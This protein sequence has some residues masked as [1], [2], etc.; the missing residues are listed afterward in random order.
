MGPDTVDLGP[1]TSQLTVYPILRAHFRA[2][3]PY[4]RIVSI[5]PHKAL[6]S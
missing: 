1:S 4:T 6:E 5:H 3:L 2:D